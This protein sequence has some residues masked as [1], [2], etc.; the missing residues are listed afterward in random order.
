[1]LK[2]YAT[3]REFRLLVQNKEICIRFL[4]YVRDNIEKINAMGVRIRP[5]IVTQGAIGESHY[6]LLKKYNIGSLPALIVTGKGAIV[7]AERIISF[8]MQEGKPLRRTSQ[9][10]NVGASDI[11]ELAEFWKQSIQLGG[12]ADKDIGEEEEPVD[13]GAKMRE[14]QAKNKSR[15]GSGKDTPSSAKPAKKSEPSAQSVPDLQ[16]NVQQTI[17]DSEITSETLSQ[18]VVKNAHNSDVP[19][20]DVDTKMLNAMLDKIS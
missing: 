7:G 8:I 11:P 14:M 5:E 3:M 1:M 17:G 9:A 18:E 20:N 6:M 10:T 16:D 13:F 15:W 4:E 19:F 2:V 12:T